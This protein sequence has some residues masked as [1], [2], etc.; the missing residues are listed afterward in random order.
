MINWNKEY[1]NRL[2]VTWEVPEENIKIGQQVLDKLNI[3]KQD[4]ILDIGCGTGVLYGLLK[5]RGC[6]HYKGID[7][8]E[9]MLEQLKK[10]F[11]DAEVSC[12]DFEKMAITPEE[13]YDYCIIFNSIPHFDNLNTTFQ[14]AYHLLKEEGKLVI[15]HCR[16]RKQLKE[17]HKKIGYISP[18][19]EPIPLD[20]E[21]IRLCRK[22]GFKNDII[23]DEDYF[24]FECQKKGIFVS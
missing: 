22:I 3:K 9:E 2:S 23:K 5:E 4:Y 11:V 16:T 19:E 1:F 15:V 20:E 6:G 21:L 8:S 7:I 12:M 24:Y 10:R 13:K 18:K 14:K 17:H